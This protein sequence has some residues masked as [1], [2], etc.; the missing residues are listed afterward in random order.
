MQLDDCTGGADSIHKRCKFDAGSAESY[1]VNMMRFY[2]Y[3]WWSMIYEEDSLILVSDFRDVFFQ[4]N[5]FDYKRETWGPPNYQLVVFLE[6]FPN[7][8]IYRCPHNSGWIKDCYG[9]DALSV[10]SDNMVSCSGITIGTRDALLVYSYLMTQQLDPK[11][12]FTRNGLDLKIDRSQIPTDNNKCS[13]NGVD[14]GFHN[15]LLYS[16]QLDKVMDIKIFPQGEGPVNTVGAFNGAQALVKKNLYEWK[17][18]RGEA[19][20][21][22][23]YN[24]NGDPSPAIHQYD[25]YMESHFKFQYE[26]YL[27]ALKDCIH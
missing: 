19:P 12:R 13:S 25:R 2:L 6:A 23:F 27:Y 18:L 14:Q 26:K 24:W 8:M 4:S 21:Q 9:S 15:F 17:V 3:Q 11:V 1:S 16:G 22:M 5:P 7:K 20:N 10:V